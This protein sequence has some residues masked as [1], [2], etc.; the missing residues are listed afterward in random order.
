M[1]R[2]TDIDQHGRGKQGDDPVV[3]FDYNMLDPETRIKV[4]QKTSEIRTVGKRVASD[5]CEMGEKFAE[6]RDLLS[7]N[8]NGSFEDWYHLE[9]FSKAF[10]YR[11]LAVHEQF[12][13]RSNL[14]RLDIAVSALYLMVSP[15]TPETVRRRLIDRAEAGERITHKKATAIINEH[16]PVTTPPKKSLA[17]T[18]TTPVDDFM[19]DVPAVEVESTP[20]HPPIQPYASSLPA[21]THSPFSRVVAQPPGA[22]L[23][24]PGNGSAANHVGEPPRRAPELRRGCY[25]VDAAGNIID[26]SDGSI[27]SPSE[28]VTIMNART[29][30]VAAPEPS[31]TEL[32]TGLHLT[33]GA[34]TDVAS[35]YEPKLVRHLCQAAIVAGVHKPLERIQ[36]TL[37]IWSNPAIEPIEK[38]KSTEKVTRVPKAEMIPMKDAIV[39]AFKWNRDKITDAT[40][41]VVNKAAM[42]LCKAGAKPEDI[43]GLYKHCE[44]FDNFSPRALSMHWADYDTAKQPTQ[45]TNPIHKRI[46]VPPEDPNAEDHSADIA[47]IMGNL[48][49][50]A[51]VTER[52]LA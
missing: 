37:T 5:I 46:E 41:G 32:E 26:T 52:R 45:S 30:Q 29:V 19:D 50:N 20:A 42:E 25:A 7:H 39:A 21:I 23:I 11:C 13:N 17:V 35:E 47:L 6:V 43:P 2:N 15:S 48:I 49:S 3:P 33:E 36:Q 34:L 38:S 51:D 27:L 24:Q 12:A 40:W 8:R 1:M 9:G 18:Y 10:V 4:E 14:E 22:S 28:I 44:Q 16:K 31:F